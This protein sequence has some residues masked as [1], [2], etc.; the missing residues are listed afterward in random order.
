MQK[1]TPLSRLLLPGL[2]GLVALGAG[3]SLYSALSAVPTSGVTLSDSPPTVP[4]A[5]VPC[6]YDPANYSSGRLVGAATNTLSELGDTVVQGDFNNDGIQDI[7]IGG[8]KLQSSRGLVHVV[9]GTAGGPVG[10]LDLGGTAVVSFYGK[11]ATHLLGSALG[12]GDVTGD[13]ITDLVVGAPGVGNVYVV[14]GSATKWT[15]QTGVNGIENFSGLIVLSISQ[16]AAAEFGFSLAVGDIGNATG[17]S[18]STDGKVDIIV[19]APSASA[20]G[21]GKGAVYLVYGPTTATNTSL[22]AA[23]NVFVFNGGTNGDRAGDTVAIYPSVT[24]VATANGI[25]DIGIGAPAANSSGGKLYLI[26]G[27]ARDYFVQGYGTASGGLDASLYRKR[28]IVGDLTESSNLK[29]GLGFAIAGIG[30]VN[31]DDINDIAVGVPFAPSPTTNTEAGRVYIFF[32]SST[33]LDAGAGPVNLS[34][35]SVPY[36]YGET[37]YDQLGSAILALNNLDGDVYDDF[38]VAARRL[39]ITTASIDPGGAYTIA[40]RSTGN[41]GFTSKKVDGY[42]FQNPRAGDAIANGG[43][44]S[45]YKGLGIAGGMDLDGDGYSDFFIGAP[46]SDVSGSN[47]QGRVYYISYGD[48]LDR[49]VDGQDR[50][51]GDCDDLSTARRYRADGS[52]EVCDGK[53]NDCDGLTDDADA[54]LVGTSYY[55]DIDGDGYGNKNGTAVQA[56]SQPLG[57]V[58]N[59]SDC[60]DSNP[61]IKPGAT[62]VCDSK[63]NNCDGL[64]DDADPA[65]TGRST[66]YK[67]TDGDGFGSSSSST[68]ACTKPTGYVS[69]STDCNDNNA[70]VNPSAQEVCDGIDND[71]D[72]FV[73]DGDSSV[74][75]QNTYYLDADGDTYGK[76]ASTT[77]TCS[78]TAPINYASKSGDCDDL[79]PAINPGAT[80]T[81]D[82]VDNDCDS[83]TDINDSPVTGT[84]SYYPDADGDTYGS[85]TATATVACPNS[86]P[87]GK[88]T[89][90]TDCDDNKAAVNTAATETCNSIDDDCDGKIDDADSSITG[91]STWYQ[92]ADGDTFGNAAKTTRACNKPTGYV[93]DKT[94][95]DD[96]NAAVKPTAQEICDNSVDNDCDGLVDDNDPSIY[97][98]QLSVTK[99]NTYY[100]DSDSDGYGKDTTTIQKCS[101]PAG[102][103]LQKGDCN[104]GNNSV[105]PGAPEGT[106]NNPTLGCVEGN[107]IDNDCDSITDEGTCD[108][109][110]DKDLQT[111]QQGDCNDANPTIYTGATEVCNGV[112]EDC[113]GVKDEDYDQDNDGQLDA[114]RCTGVSLPNATDCDD[115]DP[116]V[117]AG[118]PVQCDG[119][120][121]DCDGVFPD[122]GYTSEADADKDTFRVCASDCNDGDPVVYPDAPELCDG[123]DNNC[124]NTTD[125]VIDNDKDGFTQCNDCDDDDVKTYPGANELCD[126]KDNNCDKVVPSTGDLSESDSDGDGFKVC[127]ADCNDTD[128]DIFPDNT[129]VCDDKDNDCNDIIDDNATDVLEFYEDA[130]ADAYGNPQ[131]TVEACEPPIGYVINSTDC[132]DA[133]ASTYLGADVACDGIDHDCDGQKDYL[134]ADFDADNDGFLSETLCTNLPDEYKLDCDDSDKR[135]YPGAEEVAG[136][137]IDNNCNGQL[138]EGS[139]VEALTGGCSCSTPTG[140]NRTPPRLPVSYGLLMVGALALVRRQAH[141]HS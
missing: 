31:N 41:W 32:G 78:G 95:C 133:D 137:G 46:G 50:A 54:S 34:T 13:G 100:Q 121:T 36:F 16:G 30:D 101:L 128:E 140:D 93:S 70:A 9:Y 130:D 62:E 87:S 106:V 24:E 55:A 38:L 124:N 117:K 44:A 69:T 103:S 49:D 125:E 29:G 73:D 66:W 7:A 126:G 74:S 96:S 79:N 47:G 114:S 45:T 141:R 40:G 91:Q 18:T 35:L 61:A 109:D 76:T 42:R 71:C 84:A 60:D 80:E 27:R 110:D 22:G 37:N 112:D 3:V 53:D 77:K 26:E 105:Y 108:F 20:T 104:D 97:D 89:N 113:D 139:T 102:Y 68:V 58:S 6:T 8:P 90:N 25:P 120:D 12:A 132:D 11:S 98:G 86:P 56:C 111:E 19:G 115:K 72:V 122:T 127:Q 116:T 107:T 138:S 64:T 99:L 123:K 59:N 57:K 88:V 81:C 15:S 92:D 33:V 10:T 82:G 4:C 67:D 135:V 23:S 94:D 43:V 118:A 134:V 136:D 85:A 51:S 63:D 65:V 2:T 17:T 131:A 39:D 83:K 21:T 48:F 75:G 5:S 119:K 129:E 52:G 28:I 1:S 14:P